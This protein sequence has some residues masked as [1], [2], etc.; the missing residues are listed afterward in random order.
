[1]QKKKNL[2]LS[3]F[4]TIMCK[5]FYYFYFHLGLR[6]YGKVVYVFTLVPVFGTLVLCTKL[7][8]LTPPG[9]ISQLFPATVWN[10]FFIN[11]KSWVAASNEVFLTWGL[12]GAAAMQVSFPSSSIIAR[13]LSFCEYIYNYFFYLIFS[14][15]LFCG[16]ILSLSRI[17]A[18]SS[19]YPANFR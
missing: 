5:K 13:R 1:M 14:I 15:S 9:S 3:N 8:G 18:N 12:L 16:C 19:E 11:G 6:S 17:V 10:E 7:L 4:A 2:S